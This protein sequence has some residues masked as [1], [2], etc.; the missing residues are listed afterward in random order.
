MRLMGLSPE[1]CAT[2]AMREALSDRATVQAALDFEAALARAQARLG[3]IPAA[4]AGVIGEAADAGRFD[5]DALA[6]GAL[7]AG[8][9]AI[10]LVKALTSQV[11]AADPGAAGCVHLG[12]TSQDVAD[13]GLVLQLRR[14]VPL[15]LA[16]G[17]AVASA[18]RLLVAAH[19]DTLMLGR[20][21]L[22]PGPPITF[23]LKAAGW[24]AAVERCLARV[25]AAADEALVLQFG[26]AVGTLASLGGDGLAV[27]A[28]LGEEL[29][30]PVPD[31]PWHA[32]RDRIAALGAAV[33]VLLGALGKIA[34]DLSL[35]QQAELAEVAEPG[36]D[37]RGGS[38]TMPHKRNPT[39][40]VVILACAQRA[41]GLAA[42]LLAGMAGEHERAA[43]AWQAEAAALAELFLAA[44]GALDAAREALSGLVVDADAMRANIDRLRG[45]TLAERLT[46][47]LAPAIGRGEAHALVERLAGE[48]RG[49][50]TLAGLAAR[51]PAVR[52]HL[53]AKAIAEVFDV[54]TYLGAAAEFV[55]RMSGA[56]AAPRPVS[57]PPLAPQPA[58]AAAPGTLYERGLAVR[59]EVLGD[60]WVEKSL[61]GRDAFTGE[62][63]DFITRIAWGEVW[64]RPGLDRRIRRLLV[65]A[66]TA[67]LGRWEEFSLHVRA[68]V[69]RDGFTPDELKETLL[70]TAIYA[71]VPAANTGFKLARDVLR[72]AGR[73]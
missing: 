8:A 14:S 48:C 33:A 58:A 5:L 13:T 39:A 50:E 25:R 56:A 57:P 51:D 52:A 42:S 60:A 46:Y 64:T 66:I 6:H 31:A 32:H 41:P 65:V 54:S 27:A 21:L 36:G 17:A 4:A 12:A 44:S 38:S 3:L 62:F 10:P 18:L 2:P 30:L 67:A 55:A 40:S 43:G 11:R 68:G 15:L 61:A 37:G 1:L 63:Q 19:G 69:E 70:Q 59:R 20:T 16:D 72:E 53:D 49:R 24:L 73:L 71:G 29:G 7:R 47:R 34:R 28:A 23:A 22:Q 35:M 9:L 26:G 45:L